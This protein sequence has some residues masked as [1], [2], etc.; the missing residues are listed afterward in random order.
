MKE[1]NGGL[2]GFPEEVVEKMLERQV[3]QGNP[4]DVS[5]FEKYIGDDKQAG[6]FDWCTSP[7]GHLFWKVI[8]QEK[9][10]DTFFERYPKQE[11]SKKTRLSKSSSSILTKSRNS[12]KEEKREC[13]ERIDAILNDFVKKWQPEDIDL[14]VSSLRG[15]SGVPSVNVAIELKY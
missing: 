14:S 7:E 3:E 9:D 4:R 13:E 6:G 10:F 15:I 11:P 12:M 2:R 1:F 8:I 5:V